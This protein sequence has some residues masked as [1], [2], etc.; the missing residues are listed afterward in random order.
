MFRIV[1]LEE[2]DDCRGVIDFI[3]TWRARVVER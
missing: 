1:K 2:M 3:T